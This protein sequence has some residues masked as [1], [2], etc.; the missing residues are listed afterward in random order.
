MQGILVLECGQQA[1]E[2]ARRHYM[3]L[4]LSVLLA[5]LARC[6][7]VDALL[8]SVPS[9]GPAMQTGRQS[10]PVV[11]AGT[12]LVQIGMHASIMSSELAGQQL[13]GSSCPRAGPACDDGAWRLPRAGH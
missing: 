7:A 1:D 13:T 10:K 9:L 11:V 2:L 12:T 5:V 6:R 4:A 8:R 3:R